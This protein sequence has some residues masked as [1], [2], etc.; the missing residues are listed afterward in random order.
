M[1][2]PTPSAPRPSAALAPCSP[3]GAKPTFKRA[4]GGVAEVSTAWLADNRCKVKV[5]DVREAA[6]LV[7]GRLTFGEHIPL[8]QV[9]ALASERFDPSAPIVLVC[10]SGRR[11][12]RAA[13][14][15]EEAG[16]T[17]VASMSG[18]MLLW[19]A[20]GRPVKKGPLS[21]LPPNTKQLEAPTAPIGADA[22]E[23]H[24]GASTAL[25]WVKAAALLLH[26]KESCVDG[27]DDTSVIG[28]PGGD[29][30]ELLLTLATLEHTRGTPLTEAEVRHLFDEHLEAFGRFG[31]HTDHHAV[32][33]LAN[34]PRFADAIDE[35]GLEG[36]LAHPPRDLEGP[37]ADALTDA[38]HIGCGHL[39]LI[40]Q[41]PD[42]YNVR[43]ALTRALI[44]VALERRWQGEA[45]ELTVLEGEHNESAVVNVLLDEPVHSFTRI[46]TVPPRVNGHAIF[47]NHPEVTSW[48]R[49]ENAHFVFGSEAWTDD[50]PERRAAFLHEMAALGQQQL[51][52]T[53]GFLA[54]GLPVY[55]AHV[56]KD[57]V[58]VVEA[59]PGAPKGKAAVAKH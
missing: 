7:S 57:G 18:G 51:N 48:I 27:R 33:P 5:V 58:T 12:M 36:F 16:F 43:P 2:A 34:D 49:E 21:A 19:E 39:R 45:V 50:S 54:S 4:K 29:A 17:Q 11:S 55:E 56:R 9:Q 28:T 6:E 37:L 22:I 10:R 15:L 13:L 32:G 46:P 52:A 59:K 3:D 42:A 14:A 24:V 23:A 41:H 1:Q 25:R 38:A 44:R 40:L 20:E 30:G 47:V 26:G 8:G 31:M 35:L 53:L